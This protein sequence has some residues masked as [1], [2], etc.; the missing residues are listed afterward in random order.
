MK[1]IKGAKKIY[2]GTFS[3]ETE[4]IYLTKPS[5]DCGW[6]FG[7]LGNNNRH[8]HLSG[9]QNGRN[10]NM[11]DALTKDYDLNP[12]IE[13]NLWTFCELIQTAYTLQETAEVLVRGGSHYTTNPFSGLIQNKKEVTRINEVLLPTIFN[14]ISDLI[15]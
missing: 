5:W 9:Y 15:E 6:G 12:K 2:F 3:E 1:S 10:I 4:K 8:F 11:Y 13:K 7:Y 14:Y